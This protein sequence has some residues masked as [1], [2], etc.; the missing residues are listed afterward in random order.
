MS[1]YLQRFVIILKDVKKFYQNRIKIVLN[2]K[3]K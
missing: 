2:K 1:N 3:Y